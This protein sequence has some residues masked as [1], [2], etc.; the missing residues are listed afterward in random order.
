MNQERYESVYPDLQPSAPPLLQASTSTHPQTVYHTFPATV[1]HSVNTKRAAQVVE[2][3]EITEAVLTLMLAV[4][5]SIIFFFCIPGM[6][7]FPYLLLLKFKH[8]NSTVRAT[9]CN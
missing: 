3:D 2:Q 4:M 1:I 6:A 7:C 8:T 9:H 5:L